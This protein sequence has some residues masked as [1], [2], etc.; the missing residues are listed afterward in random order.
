MN[1]SLNNYF[2]AQSVAFVILCCRQDLKGVTPIQIV[3]NL[4]TTFCYIYIVS[5]W[6]GL[7]SMFTQDLYLYLKKKLKNVDDKW[8]SFCICTLKRYG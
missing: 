3:E 6:L 5:I 7:A 1:K 8:S 4:A 2:K